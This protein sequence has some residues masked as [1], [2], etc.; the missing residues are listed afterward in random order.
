MCHTKRH[1]IGHNS[2]MWQVMVGGGL[3]MGPCGDTSP[4]ITTRHMGELWPMLCLLMWPNN[5]SYF[6]RSR[7]TQSQVKSSSSLL[8]QHYANALFPNWENLRDLCLKGVVGFWQWPIQFYPFLDT[9][10]YTVGLIKRIINPA[11]SSSV[12]S[13]VDYLSGHRIINNNSVCSLSSL[14]RVDWLWKNTLIRAHIRIF[15]WRCN[16]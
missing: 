7:N 11:P 5:Y 10:S 1:N 2:P 13:I 15:S 14:A 3:M 12:W 6:T 4:P 9:L 16:S 8:H